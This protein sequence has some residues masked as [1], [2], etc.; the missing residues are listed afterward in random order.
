ML[1]LHGRKQNMTN[2]S[3]GCKI[4]SHVDKK[5]FINNVHELMACG[6]RA[7]Q[8]YVS[9]RISFEPG[10]PFS[11]LEVNS[12]NKLRKDNNL[13]VVVHGKQFMPG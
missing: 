10:K 7:V 1:F 9:N 12:I 4:G 13:Y 8:L 2:I 5:D 6:S 11:T 3:I